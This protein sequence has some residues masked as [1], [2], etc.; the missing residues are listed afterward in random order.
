MPDRTPHPLK[1]LVVI[2]DEW[3]YEYTFIRRPPQIRL[4]EIDRFAADYTSFQNCWP[5]SGE[6][7]RSIPSLY[8]GAWWLGAVPQTGG[9]VLLKDPA[10][11]AWQPWSTTPDLFT[12]L[13]KAGWRSSLIQWWQV[14]GPDYLQY[15]PGLE[16]F[17][18]DAD[19]LWAETRNAYASFHGSLLRQAASL[20]RAYRSYFRFFR[21][22]NGVPARVELV[23]QMRSEILSQLQDQ[24]HDLVWAHVPFP[25]S[26]A[27]IR[28]RTGQYL[29]R[30]DPAVSNLENMV[31]VDQTVGDIRRTLESLQAWDQTLIILTS[32]HWQR[33]YAGDH[34]P[35]LPEKTTHR[36]GP[37]HSPTG[38]VPWAEGPHSG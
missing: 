27:I 38:Q 29:D 35:P 28:A 17:H 24:K 12:T 15:R 34:L 10:S 9:D 30:P 18:Y 19:P 22:R 3:D 25:H 37:A 36:K 31:L 33:D 11:L 7:I 6:T 8:T 16:V 13:G 20:G 21:P 5:P 1:V 14:Y 2:F 4:P 26:P 23:Q 32:D